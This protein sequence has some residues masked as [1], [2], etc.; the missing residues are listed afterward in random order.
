MHKFILA[1]L[2]AAFPCIANATYVNVTFFRLDGYDSAFTIVTCKEKP[3]L[4]VYA[5]AH[6]QLPSGYNAYRFD[7]LRDNTVVAS[8]SGWMVGPEG[9][10]TE[11]GPYVTTIPAVSGTYTLNVTVSHLSATSQ[12]LPVTVKQTQ[13]GPSKAWSVINGVTDWQTPIEVCGAGPIVLDG[14]PSTCPTQYYLSIELS[15]Q[16][17]HGYGGEFGQWLTKAD[18]QKY[19]QIGA[20]DLK[21]WAED[22]YVGFVAGQYYRVKLAVGTPWNE[23]TKV[24]SIKPTIPHLTI[25]GTS[26]DAVNIR[27]A[28]SVI[29]DASGSSCAQSYFLSVQLSDA[30]GNRHGHEAMKWLG[31]SDFSTYGPISAF[32]VKQF[33][34]D[35]SLTFTPGQYYLVKLATGPAWTAKFVLIHILPRRKPGDKVDW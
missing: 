14:T 31:S 27:A 26:G 33:A 17:W 2:C 19:G 25:N 15:D 13:S 11:L 23:H 6:G 7:V 18:Y 34:A 10:S 1:L 32:D 22:H 9:A 8:D 5:N 12:P 16:W 3:M 30:Q 28:D 29:M 24:I 4:S 35:R 21:K 20:F